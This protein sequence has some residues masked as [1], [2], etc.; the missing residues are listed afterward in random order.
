M[1][2]Y[3][4]WRV[5][6]Y[7]SVD[8]QGSNDWKL[9]C[10][11]SSRATKRVGERKNKPLSPFFRSICVP[12]YVAHREDLSGLQQIE[13]LGTLTSVAKI[14]YLTRSEFWMTWTWTR[15]TTRHEKTRIITENHFVRTR[16]CA[17]VSN[18]CKSTSELNV[19][20]DTVNTL[21]ISFQFKYRHGVNEMK[22][23]YIHQKFG[24]GS[25]VVTVYSNFVICVECYIEPT[26]ILSP[27][28]FVRVCYKNYDNVHASI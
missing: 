28:I 24:H 20:T 13:S 15:T 16:T 10:T 23:I 17:R 1:R 3:S 18:T 21:T 5:Y 14:C 19:Y 12:T 9:Q 6:K 25:R 7:I 26:Y 22:W 2:L 4:C 8:G 27:L 11:T